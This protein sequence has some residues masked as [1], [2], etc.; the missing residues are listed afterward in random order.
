[1]RLGSAARNVRHLR[2]LSAQRGQP[3]GGLHAHEGAHRFTQQIGFVGSRIC[4]GQRFFVESI[5]EGQ[6][7]SHGRGST[8]LSVMRYCITSRITLAP[9]CAARLPSKPSRHAASLACP[10][11]TTPYACR[12]RR[13]FA[14]VFSYP[15]RRVEDGHLWKSTFPSIII[16]P[17]FQS[18]HAFWPLLRGGSFKS[19][20]E[21]LSD[22]LSVL[23]WRRAPG[24]FSRGLPCAPIDGCQKTHHDCR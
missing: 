20:Q 3:L 5:V 9:R 1:T 15:H 2:R 11:A 23:G 10:A 7:S 14:V 24:W 18:P 13:G 19:A 22:F 16:Q 4:Q 8:H 17:L 21:E 12:G 6:G